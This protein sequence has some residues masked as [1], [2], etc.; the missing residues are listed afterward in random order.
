HYHKRIARVGVDF[1]NGHNI[2]MSQVHSHASLAHELLDLY[3]LAAVT[4]AKYFDSDHA[5]GLAMDRSID[6]RESTGPDQ[7]QHLVLTIEETR[8][9]AFENSVDLKIGQQFTTLQ[10]ADQVF[11]RTIDAADFRP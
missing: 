1:V 7:V 10:H 8:T 9:L 2:G 11:T 3:R 4:A 5:T 6:P